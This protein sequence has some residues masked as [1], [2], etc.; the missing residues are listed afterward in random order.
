M[1]FGRFRTIT[2]LIE[3]SRN[4]FVVALL[5]WA[6][7]PPCLA[8][9][10]FM[11]IE[12]V[13]AGVNGDTTAQGIQ[14]RIR[15][16]GQGQLHHAKLIA[17]D[18]AGENPVVLIDFDESVPN[19][20]AG[21]RI[22]I[23]SLQM[24]AYTEPPVTEFFTMQRLIP[25]SYLEAGSILFTNDEE[26]L[27]AWRVSWGGST[28]TG[29][30]TGSSTN[31]EDR[32]FGPPYPDPLP[33]AG[34]RVLEFQGGA[35]DKST[36]NVADYQL[37]DEPGTLTNNAGE[38]FTLIIP[39]CAELDGPGPD[40]DFDTVRDACDGCPHDPEKTEPGLCGCGASEEDN[41]GNGV[42]D[43]VD[44]EGNVNSNDNTGGNNGNEND[45][46]NA[47]ENE[48]DNVEDNDNDDGSVDG[49]NGSP[50]APRGCT[51][52]FAALS[53]LTIMFCSRVSARRLGLKILVCARSRDDRENT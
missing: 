10:H 43:C 47:N 7:P 21:T 49:T 27:L 38:I 44:A 26:T 11:Q 3:I 5:A 36:S 39:D 22:L 25:L 50:A 41:N 6:L 31:D 16:A 20:Q 17:V 53:F 12:K 46:D 9:Y 24:Q 29:P 34:L 13:V 48:N 33:F 23:A 19:S 42:P 30:T 4:L 37:S 2:K 52:G 40:S 51:P 45:N 32:E 1:D 8:S 15:L 28:Y 35:S 18:A 14:L